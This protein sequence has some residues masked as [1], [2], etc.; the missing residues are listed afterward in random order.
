VKF[1]RALT[2][3]NLMR[4]A[5]TYSF[6]NQTRETSCYFYILNAN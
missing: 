5:H 4:Q 6:D 1:T 3:H 2:N